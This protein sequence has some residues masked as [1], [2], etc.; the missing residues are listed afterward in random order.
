MDF[1]V[2]DFWVLEVPRLALLFAGMVWLVVIASIAWL[3]A[4]E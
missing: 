1:P 4:R 3:M 2:P